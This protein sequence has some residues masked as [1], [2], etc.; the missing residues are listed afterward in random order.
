[1]KPPKSGR[2]TA[3]SGVAAPSSYFWTEEKCSVIAKE[4]HLYMEASFGTKA[5]TAAF[6]NAMKKPRRRA[7][8]HLSDQDLALVRRYLGAREARPDATCYVLARRV[9]QGMTAEDI[10][11]LGVAAA[12][13]ES[14]TR[15]VINMILRRVKLYEDGLTQPPLSAIPL[16]PMDAVQCI[17]DLVRRY[18]GE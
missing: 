14:R 10:N 15:A 8:K 9:A 5:A 3:L 16:N 6:T 11:R 1:M 12:A 2:D 13:G 18:R 4:L 17:E 7:L